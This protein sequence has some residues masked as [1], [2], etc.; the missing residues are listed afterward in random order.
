MDVSV[1][2]LIHGSMHGSWCWRALIPELEKRGHSA[3]GPD[4]PCEDVSAGPEDY[5]VCMEAAL[6]DARDVLL[7]GHSLGG[8]TLPLLASRVPV[9][10]MIFLCC[11]PTGIGALSPTAFK[12]MVTRE[13]REARVEVRAD[14]AR[15]M[16]GEDARDVFYHDCSPEVAARAAGSLRWRRR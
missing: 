1:F 10:G 7:V 4:L 12:G 6:G 2:A 5:A 16:Q 11:V 14:G 3:V 15:R 9:R 8:R 13:F